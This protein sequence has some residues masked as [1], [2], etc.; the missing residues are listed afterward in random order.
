MSDQKPTSNPL[1]QLPPHRARELQQELAR[2]RANGVEYCGHV[3][4]VPKHN[5]TKSEHL[6]TGGQQHGHAPQQQKNEPAKEPQAAEKGNQTREPIDFK[7]REAGAKPQETPQQTQQ[8]QSA[9]MR[10][11]ASR[12]GA[13]HSQAQE[14]TR[15]AGQ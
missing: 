3:T 12:Y 7:S 1:D 2:L 5:L 8:S 11:A 4:D 10:D 15:T 9:D 13:S 14:A 6:G